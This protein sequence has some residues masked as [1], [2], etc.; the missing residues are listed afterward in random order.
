MADLATSIFTGLE[1]LFTADTGAGG[2]NE[3][4]D[5]SNAKVRHYIRRGDANYESDRTANW[6]VVIVDVLCN[7]MR[8]FTNRHADALV[9][10]H[11]YVQRDNNGF[12]IQSAVNDR[13]V[14][15]YDGANMAAQSPFSFSTITYQRHFQA[16]TSERELHY[17]HEMSLRP[18]V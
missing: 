15:V 5:T 1:A 7:E 10:M 4:S 9:R 8:S 18:M 2:L 12:T 14:T 16:P 11:V 17:V 3:N 6:P 13:I